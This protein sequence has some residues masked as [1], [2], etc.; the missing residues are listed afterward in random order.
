MPMPIFM[1]LRYTAA[2]SGRS[3]GAPV[4]FSTS[5]AS[6]TDLSHRQS[7][8]R[9]GGPQVRIECGLECGHHL[10]HDVARRR[11]A[12]QAYVSGNR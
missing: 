9:G 10:A 6:V 7:F 12:R 5:E 4:S 1:R 11:A 3:S 8:G 2:T